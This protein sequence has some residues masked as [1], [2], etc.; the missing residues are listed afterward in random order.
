MC[1]VYTIGMGILRHNGIADV[2]A[3]SH[4]L[5]PLSSPASGHRV[6]LC[7][8][9][10]HRGQ[11]QPSVEGMASEVSGKVSGCIWPFVPSYPSLKFPNTYPNKQMPYP[12]YPNKSVGKRTDLSTSFLHLALLRC[13]CHSSSFS[14]TKVWSWSR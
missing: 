13:S 4:V 7:A 6:L 5:Q 1:H 3:T 8:L 11:H 9:E 10:K 2:D 12:S 14:K